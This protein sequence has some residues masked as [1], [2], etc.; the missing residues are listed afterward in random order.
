MYPAPGMDLLYCIYRKTIK[1]LSILGIRLRQMYRTPEI[2]LFW[3]Y[4]KL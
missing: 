2:Y 4:R 3:A 1:T